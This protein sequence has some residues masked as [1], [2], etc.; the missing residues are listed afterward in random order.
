MEKS[1]D[2]DRDR[3]QV[4][5]AVFDGLE[6]IRQSG[7]TNMLDRLVVLQLA[8]EWGF[9]ATAD[10]IERVDAATYG[11]LIFQG[12]EIIEESLDEKLDRLDREYDEE[13]RG[14][15]EGI[16]PSPAAAQEAD[17][18]SQDTTPDRASMRSTLVELG[19]RASLAMADSYET[20]EMGVL[21]DE[22]LRASINAERVA[23]ISTLIEASNLEDQLTES[24]QEVQRRI[25]KLTYLLDPENH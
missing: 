3:V 8:R 21:M 25:D 12:P 2:Q 11:R 15:W 4:T 1:Q 17:S 24:L 16:E 22:S 14:F 9:T 5:K 7:A 6:I 23:L 13:R 18:L 20:E 10:W 19:K